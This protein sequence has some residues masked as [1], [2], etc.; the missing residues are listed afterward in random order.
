MATLRGDV[1]TFMTRRGS[2][3]LRMRNIS[4]KIC[5]EYQNTHFRFNSFLFFSKIV[6]LMRD[7]V[8][9]CGG[10]RED[11]DNMATARGVLHK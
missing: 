6:P 10:A 9:K 5:R 11:A 3:F 4:N 7:N 8:E 2:F 1:S